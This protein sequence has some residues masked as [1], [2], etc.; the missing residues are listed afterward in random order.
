MQLKESEALFLKEKATLDG[1]DQILAA[2]L[3]DLE[4]KQKELSGRVEKV[5]LARYNKLKA[6]RKDQALA[7]IRNGICVGCRL[8]LPPQ[9]ISQVKRG[10]EVHTCP[11]CYR[12]L[13]WEGEPG[14][15][16]KR[17]MGQDQAK[18]LEVGE[19]F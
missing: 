12:M 2:E 1:K 15:E 13:Y 11:Y 7:L 8:Q 16:Q 4:S 9:L 17:S 3:A 14:L 5:L 6:T 18:D 19:S 10:D